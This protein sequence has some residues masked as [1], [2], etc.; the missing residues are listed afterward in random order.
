MNNKMWEPE[1][2]DWSEDKVSLSPCELSTHSTSRNEYGVIVQVEEGDECRAED[3]AIFW[4]DAMHIYLRYEWG[5]WYKVSNDDP[6]NCANICKRNTA[7]LLLCTTSSIKHHA[8]RVY[9]IDSLPKELFGKEESE[10]S[11]SGKATQ[12][13][14]DLPIPSAEGED[15]E[16]AGK[17]AELSDAAFLAS[18]IIFQGGKTVA[19]FEGE[20]FAPFSA[21]FYELNGHFIAASYFD[22]C[23]DWMA[24][25]DSEDDDTP[26]WY[27][28][29]GIATS[30]L[31]LAAKIRTAIAPIVGS[32]T[33]FHSLILIN[34]R[35]NITN[36]ICHSI[37]WKDTEMRLVRQEQV[38]DSMLDTVEET[39]KGYTGD[40]RPELVEWESRLLEALNAAFPKPAKK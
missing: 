31:A 3:A 28:A 40:S 34:K 2:D 20:C 10:A 13:D 25:E 8:V 35:C 6:D 7:T 39:L 22:K 30:P 33:P 27:G 16:E 37:N 32:E 1:F 23:G 26:C 4:T 15:D 36:E 9:H 17:C 24:D 19:H 5:L 21:D 29:K 14:F 11:D 38:A 18:T 12:L